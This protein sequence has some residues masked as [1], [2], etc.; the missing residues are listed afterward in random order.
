MHHV[1]AESKSN[2]KERMVEL[3]SVRYLFT[4]TNPPIAEMSAQMPQAPTDAPVNVENGFTVILMIDL[5][6]LSGD[7]PLLE[8]PGVIS[9]VFRN[10]YAGQQY[11]DPGIDASASFLAYGLEA[12]AHRCAA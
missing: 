12:H 6:M 9:L 4:P 2:K 3:S 5:S 1:S 7:K 11:P 8:V 10:A